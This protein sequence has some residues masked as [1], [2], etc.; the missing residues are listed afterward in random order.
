MLGS[1]LGMEPNL[2]KHAK[3]LLL[4]K[5]N[6]YT[7]NTHIYVASEQELALFLYWFSSL[8]NSGEPDS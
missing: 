8:Q 7:Y 1:T 2:K 4:L 3:K 6:A 5:K